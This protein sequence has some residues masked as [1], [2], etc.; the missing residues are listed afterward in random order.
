MYWKPTFKH[1]SSFVDTDELVK[2]LNEMKQYHVKNGVLS[3][4]G[5]HPNSKVGATVASIAA[6]NEWG[7]PT[8]P[9]RP[10]MRLSYEEFKRNTGFL[11]SVLRALIFVKSGKRLRKK[12][13]VK[14]AFEIFGLEMMSN[15]IGQITAGVPPA[16][17]EST[18]ARKGSSHP[19]FDTSLLK[20]SLSYQVVKNA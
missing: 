14:K 13:S 4:I 1:F 9:A 15:M 8:I 17:A 7:T 3:G 20:Q 10:F 11:I 6:W 19:L 12:F 16:N 18:I 5:A 2:R